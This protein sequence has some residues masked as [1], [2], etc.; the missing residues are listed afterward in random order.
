MTQGR[1]VDSRCYF[2]CDIERCQ[3]SFHTTKT[4]WESANAQ[5]TVA[6][7]RFGKSRGGVFKAI[8]P[9]H[10]ATTVKLALD[11]R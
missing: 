8:C 9:D 7:W 4:H 2:A 6:G 5:A 3:A 10:H 1:S 11:Q